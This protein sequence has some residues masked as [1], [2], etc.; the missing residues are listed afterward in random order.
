MNTSVT[1]RRG[2][3]CRFLLDTNIIQEQRDNPKGTTNVTA[4]QISKDNNRERTETHGYTHTRDNKQLK[5]LTKITLRA[6]LLKKKN[7]KCIAVCFTLCAKTYICYK[8]HF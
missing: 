7:F 8:Q 3:N 2:S 5:Y 1:V 6:N 4:K